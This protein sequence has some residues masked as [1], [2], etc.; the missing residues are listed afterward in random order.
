ME[1]VTLL[2]EIYAAEPLRRR[3]CLYYLAL[4]YFKLGN[5]DHARRFNS[6]SIRSVVQLALPF[7]R[8][9][10]C[11]RPAWPTELRIKRAQPPSSCSSTFACSLEHLADILSCLSPPDL[12]LSKEP[13]NLQAQSLNQ[14]IDD[15]LRK[16][17]RTRPSRL[18]CRRSRGHSPPV[19]TASARRAAGLTRKSYLLACRGLPGNGDRRRSGCR[20]RRP[21]RRPPSAQ[22]AQAIDRGKPPSVT[23]PAAI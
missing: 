3:E 11:Q 22:P 18:L 1:G 7:S 6:A 21:R 8:A 20:R 5:W 2:Q 13:T 17:A 14:L 9:V 19:S 23:C 10:R 12:L 16:G 4:G 15:G